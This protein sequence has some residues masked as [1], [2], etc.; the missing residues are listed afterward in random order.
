MLQKIKEKGHYQAF[1][2]TLALAA[3]VFLPF[4]IYDKGIFFFYGDFNVQQIPFYKLAHEAI[5]SG[6]IAW[7]WYTDLGA[8]FI[9]PI[10]FTV[11]QPFFLADP[12]VPNRGGTVPHRAAADA[13]NQP[14][15]L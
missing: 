3:V 12:P 7:N 6:D 13:Q 8:N 11:V 9:G 15:P 2:I 5:R 14:V 10:A 4:I 1:F